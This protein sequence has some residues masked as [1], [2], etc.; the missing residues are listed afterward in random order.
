MGK[1]RCGAPASE[2]IAALVIGDLGV[3]DRGE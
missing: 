1:A 2:S 3:K